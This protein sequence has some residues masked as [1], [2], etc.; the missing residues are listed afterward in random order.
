MGIL[1]KLKFQLYPYLELSK[2]AGSR[3]WAQAR[4]EKWRA[5]TS[6]FKPE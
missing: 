3:G 2:Q 6:I 5:W 4:P 1:E